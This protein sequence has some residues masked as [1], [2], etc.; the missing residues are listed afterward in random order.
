MRRVALASVVWLGLCASA[1]AQ[2][3][4]AGRPGPYVVD[5]RGA[6]MGLPR[7]AAFYPE[8]PESTAVPSRG[9]GFDAGVHLYLFQLGPARLG[10]GG[11]FLRARG[12]A[13][14]GEIDEDERPASGVALN[15]DVAALLTVY[16]PQL[17]LNF[18]SRAGWSY[19]SAG[20]GRAELTTRT[21]AFA[22]ED[23]EDEVTP[24]QLVDTGPRS[25]INIGGGARWFAKPRLAFTFDV[26]FHVVSS[27]GGDR[28]TPGKTLLSAS[29]GLSVR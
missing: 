20:V 1:S 2:D 4:G 21:T 15:P 9:F 18:G 17:S 12:T 23:D 19:L 3:A 22:D 26:R 24:A 7:D 8:L 5:V 6:T 11:M 13:S 28:P 25:A 10:I 29:A 16:G 27:G 14:P